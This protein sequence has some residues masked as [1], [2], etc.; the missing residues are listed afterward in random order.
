[1]ADEGLI[2][3]GIDSEGNVFNEHFGMAYAYRIYNREG[4]LFEIRD[5]PL[6]M[7]Q[8][9]E[10]EHSDPIQTLDLLNDCN[11]FIAKVTGPYYYQ[12]E[13]SG[14]NVVITEADDPD[15]A[16]QA[17]LSGELD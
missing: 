6:G 3:V 1:M 11:V 4:I 2:A 15:E 14:V 9:G 5:N 17:F 12:V 10:V 7:G 13:R 16:L 8:P